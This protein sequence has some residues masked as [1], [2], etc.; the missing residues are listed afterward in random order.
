[1]LQVLKNEMLI[2]TCAVSLYQSGV[3][4]IESFLASAPIA[5]AGSVQNPLC[6]TRLRTPILNTTGADF[7]VLVLLLLN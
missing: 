3:C 6:A 7:S 2:Q 1:M 5:C 4:L